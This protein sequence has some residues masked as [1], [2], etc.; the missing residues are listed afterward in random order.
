[1]SFRIRVTDHALDR[2]IERIDRRGDAGDIE[3]ALIMGAAV[4]TDVAMTILGRRPTSHQ[5]GDLFVLTPCGR[6]LIVVNADGLVCSVFQV[7]RSVGSVFAPSTQPDSTTA[8]AN[9]VIEGDVLDRLMSAALHVPIDEVMKA[10]KSETARAVVD[11]TITCGSIG[12]GNI[13]AKQAAEQHSRREWVRSALRAIEM[14]FHRKRVDG[15]DEAPLPP[16]RAKT[17]RVE[18]RLTAD[19]HDRWSAAAVARGVALADLIREAM[20]ALLGERR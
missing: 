17:S 2:W 6:G 3:R 5:P 9:T 20:A 4:S 19:E 18:V 12:D 13:T 7:N 15:V 10:A 8:D 14:S 1:M 11:V 16:G